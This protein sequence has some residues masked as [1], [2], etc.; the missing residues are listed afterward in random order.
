MLKFILALVALALAA[1]AFA[2]YR[3]MR[4]GSFF[5]PPEVIDGE[6]QPQTLAELAKRK[7]SDP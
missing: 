7:E 4:G 6:K 1:V 2:A 5:P 3:K